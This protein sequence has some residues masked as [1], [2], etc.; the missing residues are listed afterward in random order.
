MLFIQ[1]QKL[2]SAR[3][4]TLYEIFSC[5]RMTSRTPRLIIICRYCRNESKAVL[6]GIAAKK[7]RWTTKH[8]LKLVEST[9]GHNNVTCSTHV[10]VRTKR[11]L[12]NPRGT[13]VGGCEGGWCRLDGSRSA[14]PIRSLRQNQQRCSHKLLMHLGNIRTKLK[15]FYFYSFHKPL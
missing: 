13:T 8:P 6:Y 9:I 3:C 10:Q 14:T 4:E 5:T 1:V 12:H 7:Y 2:C 15:H 11:K